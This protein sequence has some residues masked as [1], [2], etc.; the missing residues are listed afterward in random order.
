MKLGIVV[1]KFNSEI[2]S[3]GLDA[4]KEKAKKLGLNIINVIEVF[5][6]FDSPLAVSALF[7]SP[8]IDAV[9]VIGAII[10]GETKH[11][12]AIAFTTLKT[13]QE[14]SLQFNKP[15]GLAISGPGMTYEQAVKRAKPIAENAVEAVKMLYLKEIEEENKTRIM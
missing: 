7:N 13:L 10:K 6:A 8:E 5:G 15:I 12:E 9:I 4:A 14:L 11:D 1:A 3:I 2:T